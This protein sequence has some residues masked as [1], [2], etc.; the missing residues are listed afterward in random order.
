MSDGV[1]PTLSDRLQQAAKE[2]SVS[3]QMFQ[4]LMARHG[5]S[6]KAFLE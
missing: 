5:V 4:R 6:R 3:R 1:T 2:A